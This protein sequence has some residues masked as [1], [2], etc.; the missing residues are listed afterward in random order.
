MS[1]TRVN[2]QDAPSVSTPLSASNLNK[3]DAGIKQNADDIE[4]LQQHTY[5]S[6]LNDTSTN[7]PQTKVVKKAIE[8]AVESVTII[9]DPTLSNEG[10]AADAKATGEAVAQVKSALENYD[11][12]KKQVDVD[13]EWHQGFINSDGT[14]DTSVSTYYVTRKIKAVELNGGTI[15]STPSYSLYAYRY[16]QNGTYISGYLTIGKVSTFNVPNDYFEPYADVILEM[17][18][19]GYSSVSAKGFEVTNT[20]AQIDTL[21]EESSEVPKVVMVDSLVALQDEQFDV[22]YDNIFVNYRAKDIPYKEIFGN[23]VCIGMENLIRFQDNTVRQLTGS[24]RFRNSITS[25]YNSPSLPNNVLRK[26]ITVNTISAFAGSGVTR[27][28]LLIGDSWTAPGKYARELRNLFESEDEPM[29]ITLLGT[30]GNGG[31]YVG[32]EN[33]YHE[34]HGAFSSKTFCTKSTHNTY[35]NAFYNPTTETFDFSY[36]MNNCGYSSVDDV[37][38]NLGVNDVA[39]MQD[40]DE[41]ISYWD[42]M[43]N[44]IKTYNSNIKVFIG[45]CGLPAQYKY[46]T[47]NNNCNR[48]K[49]RRLLFHERLISEYGNRES[50]GLII[51]PLHLSIDTEHDFPTAQMARS[52]RDST[53]VDYCTDNVHPSDIAYNKIA[54]RIRTYIKYAETLN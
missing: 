36:Y 23:A 38:I 53:L 24:I 27:K 1:Y 41:I 39:E 43:I 46:S 34:G 44:S 9:T 30:L 3:M 4:Q 5:D 51:V 11:E 35:A 10:Q 14:I 26:A 40:F 28:V 21:I 52:Y 32:P 42:I 54:D 48:S 19:N 12:G 16:R 49:A 18:A 31:A 6:A 15:T 20:Q 25:A 29:N 13:M 8:D 50:D 33:G 17:S 45:L 37:F 22:M 2:W 7:A 47:T